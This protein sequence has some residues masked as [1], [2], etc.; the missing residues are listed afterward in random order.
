ML[1]LGI[2]ISAQE[3]KTLEGYVE[4]QGTNFPQHTC[5]KLASPDGRW[6]TA[7]NASVWTSGLTQR[8]TAFAGAEAPRAHR[9][10]SPAAG[11][12]G[13]YE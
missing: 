10:Q 5:A 11:R 3:S 8:A 9:S 13:R 4:P 2:D 12:V 1:E 7:A 6:R